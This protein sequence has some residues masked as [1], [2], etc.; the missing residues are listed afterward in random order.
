MHI[1]IYKKNLNY[2]HI[3]MYNQFQNGRVTLTKEN[4]KDIKMIDREDEK[5][6]NF[7][8]EALYGIQETSILNNAFFSKKNMDII[9]NMIRYNVYEKSDKK[10]IIDKQSDVEL[11]IVMRS[12]YLQHSPNLPNKITEQINYLNKLV[13]D[14]CVEQI[15]PEVMQYIGYIKEI[16]YMPVPIDL[17][18]NLSSKGSRSLRS[19]TTTF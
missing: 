7:Q 10:Y 5:M 4:M 13:S 12:I 18:L 1:F 6:N 2:I 11:E 19:V 14:W 8:V 9:Q 17:P 15:I 3:N 16:E